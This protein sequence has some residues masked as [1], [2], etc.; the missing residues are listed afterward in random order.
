MNNED[1]NFMEIINNNGMEHLQAESVL[2]TISMQD[3]IRAIALLSECSLVMA[4]FIDDYLD[5]EEEDDETGPTMP[6]DAV[7]HAKLLI[8]N[9]EAFV[10]AIL[11]DKQAKESMEFDED[12]DDF[13]EDDSDD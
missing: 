3:L 13:T 7:M 1:D 4:N 6:I 10:D 8:E 11:E 2:F 12:E 5:D 9:A